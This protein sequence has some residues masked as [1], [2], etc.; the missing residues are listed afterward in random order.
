MY[1]MSNYAYMTLV[2]KGD[3]YISGAIVLAEG[4]RKT[5]T[6]HTIA[7]MITDDV[8]QQ[9]R[10]DLAKAF[11]CIH[12]V[13][14]YNKEVRPLK[15]DK[16]RQKYDKWMSISLT[17]FRCLDLTE[18]DK[19]FLLD[20]DVAVLNNM[21]H[22]FKLRAPA[23]SF[24]SF[25]IKPYYGTL[26]HGQIVPAA[27]IKRAF[28]DTRGSYVCIGN[29]L[30]LKPEHGAWRAFDQCMQDFAKNN[31]GLLG[32]DNSYSGI[33]EQM[34]AYFYWS[35]KI[36]WTHI[37]TQFQV[38]PWKKVE[39]LDEAPRLFHYFNIK[40]WRMDLTAFP[41]L[42]V[43]WR[44]AKSAWHRN[45]DILDYIPGEF[46]GNLHDVDTFMH[47]SCLWCKRSGH[48]FISSECIIICPNFIDNKPVVEK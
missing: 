30:L 40:P 29:G 41:D 22:V 26:R 11:D 9:G 16:A 46:H 37:G 47:D 23:G 15:T 21:D 13:E 19:I 33:N 32:F 7:C 25:W 17:F 38:I 5:C 34:I 27:K 24:H 8:S 20:S 18:Y 39:H 10:D 28:Q 48:T 31:A 3:E 42:Q 45:K 36:D 2:M 14:Y 4:L 12:V 6:E 44:F 1:S 35:N 43:W